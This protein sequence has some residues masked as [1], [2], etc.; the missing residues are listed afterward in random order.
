MI[1][2]DNAAT[3]R[4]NE[5]T[6]SIINEYLSEK[7]YN[8]S[9][10]YKQAS[11]V[12]RDIRFAREGICKILNINNDELYYVSSGTE[13][14]NAALLLSR[15]REASRIIISSAEHS[16][17]YNTTQELTRQGY[18]VVFAPVDS[19]G[20]VIIEKFLDLITTNTSLVSIIHV[21][22]ET[23]AINDICKLSS[24]A[25]KI[26]KNILFHSDGV[27]AFTKIKFDLGNSDVDLYSISGHK[28]NAP[29]G[30][31]G[32]YVRR[33]VTLKPL[34]F[35]GG[36]E[37]NVRSS[38]ENTSGIIALTYAANYSTLNYANNYNTMKELLYFISDFITLNINNAIINTNLEQSAPNIVSIALPYVRGEVLM[39]S[40]EK[41]NII[42]GIGS[43]CT[44]KKGTKRIPTALNL[45]KEYHEGMIRLSIS[46]DI[47]RNQLEFACEKIVEEYNE[48]VKYAR[49]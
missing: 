28:V 7:F 39:H 2:L 30:V 21:N 48:L 29:K 32:L 17:V 47:T 43:A 10:L 18:E 38:T 13:A 3:T 5:D 8:P 15:K 33:G 14:D 12:A 24:E 37:N 9:A 46:P 42:I 27:Q 23:G 4:V 20:K 19:H 49:R 26:N 25:K 11:D 22:N 41:H 34:L 45:P 1:Y 44:S 36:Q 6:L 31:G 35:G 40:L 16:A